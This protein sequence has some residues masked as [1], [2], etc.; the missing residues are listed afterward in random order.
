MPV[1]PDSLQEQ[2]GQP[3]LTLSGVEEK[4]KSPVSQPVSLS[5]GSPGTSSLSGR[6]KNRLI[7]IGAV[8]CVVA[9]LGMTILYFLVKV[10]SSPDVTVYQVGTQNVSQY[11]GG[12]GIVFPHDQ[13]DVSY[14]LAERVIAVLVKPG[15]V[16]SPKQPLIQLD[17]SQLNVQIMQASNDLAADLAYLNS[18][19]VS[20]NAVTIA[21][22]QQAYNIAKDKYNALVAQAQSP[23]LQ[24]GTL[25]SPIRGVVTALNVD[26]G[27]V[28]PANTILL[29]IKDESTVIVHVKVPLSN[30]GQVHLGQ[31]AIVTP[32]ALPDLNII[33]TVSAVI[34]NADPQTDTFEVWVQVDNSSGTLLPGMTAFVRIQITGRALAVP[35]LAVLNPDRDSIVF[36]VRENHVYVQHVHV[37]G[38]SI[39]SF[40]IDTG[41][42]PGDRVVLVR[43][44]TLQNGQKIHVTRIEGQAS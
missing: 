33:G 10:L 21:Q 12:G 14:P 40:Y 15:D 24:H 19:S 17:P 41:L 34:P 44:D 9:L 13:L 36:L 16:I 35:R 43:L 29:T 39:Q 22:A 32:S 38:R 42:S 2:E 6:K 25:I 37:A 1:T 7:I 30:L 20:G 3:V 18:V 8:L 5:Q 26:S 4:Q 23:T 31:Q 11:V 28:F 27:D